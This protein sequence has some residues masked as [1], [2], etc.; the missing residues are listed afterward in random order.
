[1]SAAIEEHAATTPGRTTTP[2]HSSPKRWVA[3]VGVMFA[4]GWGGNQFTPLLSVYREQDGYSQIS[5]DVFLGAYVLGLIPGL[6][7]GFVSLHLLL[8][9]KLG[10]NEWPMPGRVVRRATY[11][12]EY[13]ELTKQDGVPFFPYA[14]WKDLFFAACI[15]IAVAACALYF[16]PFGP[17][18]QPAGDPGRRSG[19]PHD[20][21]TVHHVDADEHLEVER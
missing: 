11:A 18:G 5:V 3:V 20:R 17:T 8:V 15:L 4:I 12:S 14:I 7:I 9:L 6:L 2:A 19:Q 16:G 10:I 21:R 1:M 13:H